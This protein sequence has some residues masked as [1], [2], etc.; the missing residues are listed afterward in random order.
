MDLT[1][2]SSYIYN[3]PKEYIAQ[4]PVL[5]RDEC[6]L[7]HLDKANGSIKHRKF[8]DIISLF[9]PDDVLV[10]NTTKVIPARLIG[11]KSTGAKIEVLL[12]REKSTSGANKTR[13]DFY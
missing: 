5:K 6:L 2:R 9:Q 3:L 1:R 7:L 8:V 4:H 11:K 12:L 10:I 13:L